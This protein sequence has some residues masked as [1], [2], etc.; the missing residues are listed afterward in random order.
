MDPTLWIK[1]HKQDPS[2]LIKKELVAEAKPSY[3]TERGY[4]KIRIMLDHMEK[5]QGYN[6]ASRI[7][8]QNLLKAEGM[9]NSVIP[10][11]N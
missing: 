9:S 1:L 3:K 5:A 6:E 10:F 8:E 4:A 11:K 7:H 2:S